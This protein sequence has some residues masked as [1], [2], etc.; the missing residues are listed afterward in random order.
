VPIS[1]A[2]DHL[3]ASCAFQH[4]RL[5]NSSSDEDEAQ[6]SRRSSGIG[7]P[8]GRLSL[9]GLPFSTTAHPSP[10]LSKSASDDEAARVWSFLPPRTVIPNVPPAPTDA[11]AAAAAVGAPAEV[12]LEALLV[13]GRILDLLIA[14]DR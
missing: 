12:T 6:G 3:V 1:R 9:V 4:T 14:L 10:V 2:I 7:I 13:S 5:S 8:T 11:A